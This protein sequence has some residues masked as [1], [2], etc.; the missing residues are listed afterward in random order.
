VSDLQNPV[1]VVIGI[2]DPENGEGPLHFILHDEGLSADDA[3]ADAFISAIA[4][5]RDIADALEARLAH[6]AN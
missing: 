6:M 5:L 1:Q 4:I 2:A 3:S